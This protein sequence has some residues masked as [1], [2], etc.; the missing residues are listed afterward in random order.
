MGYNF[1][2]IIFPNYFV[3]EVYKN[4]QYGQV[5]SSKDVIFDSS[6]NFR[7]DTPL[8]PEEAFRPS[9]PLPV[10]PTPTQPHAPVLPTSNDSEHPVPPSSTVSSPDHSPLI[11][12]VRQ[13]PV[14]KENE[15]PDA[16][17]WYS[18]LVDTHEYPLKMVELTHYNLSV[19]I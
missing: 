19:K 11:H 4:G 5:R 13:P 9:S 3:V 10:L 1:S 2:T 12:R 15:D 8:P 6:I 14:F 18:I 7:S 16:V 17:Y